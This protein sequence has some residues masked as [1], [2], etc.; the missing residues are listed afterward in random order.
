MKLNWFNL[1]RLFTGKFLL[2]STKNLAKVDVFYEVFFSN[3]LSDNLK[4]LFAKDFT[5]MFLNFAYILEVNLILRLNENILN[6]S[7]F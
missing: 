7:F 6:I 2:I 4:N 1:M 5:E 3:Y